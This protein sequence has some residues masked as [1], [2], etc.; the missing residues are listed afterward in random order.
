MFRKTASPDEDATGDAASLLCLWSGKE[1]LFKARQLG[2]FMPRLLR[3]G[4]ET[5]QWVLALDPAILL[6]VTGENIENV[7]F[8]LYRDGGARRIE[9]RLIHKGK[10]SLCGYFG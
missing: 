2:F 4:P 8:Y 7:R 9:K 3:L 10:E 1:S 5:E 6:S